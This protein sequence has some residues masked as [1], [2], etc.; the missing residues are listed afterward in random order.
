MYVYAGFFK[1]RVF[2]ITD[3]RII[4]SIYYVYKLFFLI[5]YICKHWPTDLKW[6][7]HMS[8]VCV[9][10]WRSKHDFNR[11]ILTCITRIGFLL[12]VHSYTAKK[13]SLPENADPK[14]SQ[15]YGFSSEYICIY[16]ILYN[17]CENADTKT[18]QNMISLQYR[19][20]LF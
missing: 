20:V 12:C 7:W 11:N 3:F 17:N 15:E 13:N 6:I 18:D 4:F 1:F 5:H 9:Y 2:E 8:T 14:T 10:T 16:H 19:F